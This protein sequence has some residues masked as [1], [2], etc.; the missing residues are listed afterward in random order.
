MEDSEGVTETF[1]SR[2]DTETD[3]SIEQSIRETT[4]EDLERELPVFIKPISKDPYQDHGLD[5]DAYVVKSYLEPVYLT[6]ISSLESEGQAEEA[7]GAGSSPMVAEE[8][9]A[10]KSEEEAQAEGEAE[11]EAADGEIFRIPGTTIGDEFL[12]EA[13]LE[14]FIAMKEKEVE[15]MTDSNSSSYN[16]NSRSTMEEEKETSI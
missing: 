8:D 6:E 5:K 1:S 2:E 13:V 11:G 16:S 7:S 15:A 12:E 9:L 3:S 10:S 14:E 4:S